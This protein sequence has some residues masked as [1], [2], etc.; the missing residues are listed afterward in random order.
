MSIWDDPWKAAFLSIVECTHVT[1]PVFVGNG[2]VVATRCV[3]CSRVFVTK[4]VPGVTSLAVPSRS[5]R[6]PEMVVLPRPPE[7]KQ[8]TY[9]R[10]CR[11]K[12]CEEVF[13]V[14]SGGRPREYCTP[15]HS[16]LARKRGSAWRRKPEET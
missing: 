11:Y 3:K 9:E 5:P 10:R 8:V 16:K 12:P 15:A 2:E 1:E 14:E 4:E 7:R 13:V 6:W